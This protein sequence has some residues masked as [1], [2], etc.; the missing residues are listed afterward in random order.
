V[1]ETAAGDGSSTVSWTFITSHGLVLL[2]IAQDPD[3]RLRDIASSVGITERAVQ[4]IVSD[5]IDAGYLSKRRE[6]RR[7]AYTLHPHQPLP[8]ASTRHQEV[9]ELMRTLMTR[10]DAPPSS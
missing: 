4:R 7:N 9:G 1:G 10:S 8:H 3:T 6:G 5:L 2:A